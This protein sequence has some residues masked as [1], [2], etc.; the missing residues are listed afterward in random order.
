MAATTLRV[1]L[2]AGMAEAAGA[3]HLAIAW[4]GGTV[5]ELRSAVAAACPAIVAL[6]ARST[7][8]IDGRYATDASAVP[9]TA[10][11]AVIPPVSGG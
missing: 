5:G 1:H 8:A 10:D 6:L 11:V 4:S 7:I 2:F 9:V 3:R